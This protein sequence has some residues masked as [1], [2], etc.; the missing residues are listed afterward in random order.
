MLTLDEKVRITAYTLFFAVGNS[1]R[2][3]SGH[4]QGRLIEL[5][6]QEATCFSCRLVGL[7]GEVARRSL[8][9]LVA[10][11]EGLLENLFNQATDVLA[12]L[13]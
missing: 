1:W 11:G 10:E 12:L 2:Y 9:R 8:L 13:D 6:K 5:G 3:I 4:G 7:K